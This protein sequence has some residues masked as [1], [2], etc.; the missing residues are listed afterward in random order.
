M[1][2][3]VVTVLGDVERWVVAAHEMPG[4]SGIISTVRAVRKRKKATATDLRR[5]QLLGVKLGRKPVDIRD[6]RIAEQL[7]ARDKHMT[8]KKSTSKKTTAKKS[9]G[10]KSTGK[11]AGSKKASSKK[12]T[13]KAGAKK[14][15]R[16]KATAKKTTKQADSKDEA[17]T[18]VS[19]PT[20]PNKET[21]MISASGDVSTSTHRT[22]NSPPAALFRPQA[23]A[24][25]ATID[26][27][28]DTTVA[29]AASNLPSLMAQDST[30]TS[31]A[32]SPSSHK[33]PIVQVL[34]LSAGEADCD[35]QDDASSPIQAAFGQMFSRLRSKVA[36]MWL[37]LEAM[38]GTPPPDGR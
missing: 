19:A 25:A 34:G 10:K 1:D 20:T 14:T 5:G 8:S 32:A 30:K 18:Q 36:K 38:L 3:V 17:S 16:K 9:T 24:A 37:K 11:K 31:S 22:W 29:P 23:E 13:K 35:P 26:T 27:A 4:R 2:P 15:T 28:V 6:R 12:A 7:I 21:Q 33:R